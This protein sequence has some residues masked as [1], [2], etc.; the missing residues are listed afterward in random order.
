MTDDTVRKST[1]GSYK[2]IYPQSLSTMLANEG[3]LSRQSLLSMSKATNFT[4]VGLKV[5][6][7]T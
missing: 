2:T 5:L 7:L 3:V 6:D 1:K 4:E